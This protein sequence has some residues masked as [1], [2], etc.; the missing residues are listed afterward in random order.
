MEALTW[1][2]YQRARMDLEDMKQNLYLKVS[3]AREAYDPKNKYGASSTTFLYQVL[4][5][6]ALD[7]VKA[8]NREKRKWER[9]HVS[10]NQNATD[11]DD[12]PMEEKITDVPD[13]EI[14]KSLETI[15]QVNKVIETLGP[16]Y[17]R[18]CELG[19]LKISKKK[20]SDILGISRDTLYQRLR[21]LRETFRDAGF[22]EYLDPK[23]DR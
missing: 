6:Q 11:Q 2:F 22:G 8:A 4:Y 18:I 14:Q 9:D 20:M 1:K 3:A 16:E 12:R 23:S 10:I 7:L 17:R 5:R 19:K 13:V 15:A 21:D